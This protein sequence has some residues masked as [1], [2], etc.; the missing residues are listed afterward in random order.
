MSTTRP[1]TIKNR[2]GIHVRPSGI[3]VKE[4]AKFPDVKFAIDSGDGM[5][6]VGGIMDMLVL[7]LNQGK[8][9]TLRATGP[10]EEAAADRL[11]ELLQFDFDYER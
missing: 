1:A 9:V 4:M 8:T 3:I 2:H 5:A 7:D 11:A 10:N 6:L